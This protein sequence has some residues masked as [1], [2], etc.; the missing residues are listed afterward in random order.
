MADFSAVNIDRLLTKSF[1]VLDI[2]LKEA[3]EEKLTEYDLSKTKVISLLNIDKD[4]F[5]DIINGTAKQPTL[6]NVIKIAHFLELGIDQ[7]IP[8]I[9]KNQP[10]ESIASIER[11][12]KA[13]FIAKNFDIKK[14]SK[15]GFLEE[16]DNI[17]YI[18]SRLLSFFGYGSIY[19]YET[20][21][22]SPLYSKSKR[23]FSDKMKSFWIN[24]A[25]QCFKNIDNPNEYNREGLKD[26]I[27]KIKPY[28][29]DVE[30]GLFIVCKAL[31]NVGVTTIAQNHLT[32]TQ[33]RGG[34][35]VVNEKPC[36]V[37]TDLF[38][39]YTTIWETLIH[40]LH[41]VLY[42]LKLISNTGFHLTGD[43]DLFLIEDK[44]EDFSRE[45]FC[46]IN[47]YNYIKPHIHNHFMVKRYA[48]ELEIHPAFVYSSFR[49]FQQL[50][51]KKNYYAA[52]QEYFPE[53]TLKPLCPITWKENSIT[54]AA[55][56]IKTIFELNV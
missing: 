5:E 40:E 2:D 36:I 55:Q 32:L 24:S 28:S 18:T 17:D 9:L 34:T 38:K 50:F 15:I 26:I 8:A 42:D 22:I 30:N 35:F 51:H 45:Y 53:Y 10:K 11:A 46:G 43:P 13:S 49:Q 20:Q 23:S 37:L 29:Q 16:S 6:I 3:L 33:V 39:R 27:T 56:N 48:S 47:Q 12:K 54:E 4:T 14:L 21:L 19:D 52:F 44:A 31:Y 25:F 41:H 1:E 7:I